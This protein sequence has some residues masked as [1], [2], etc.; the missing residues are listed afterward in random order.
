MRVTGIPLPITPR[1]GE[2]ALYDCLVDAVAFFAQAKGSCS[3]VVITNSL[4]LWITLFQRIKPGSVAFVSAK[5][6]KSSLEFAFLPEK[7][8]VQIL[9][10]PTLEEISS[11][12][13]AESPASPSSFHE[14]ESIA[15]EDQVEAD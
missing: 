13:Q 2:S 1:L 3:F 8:P 7:I 9:A 10:W 15:E 11:S 12:S 5:G 14:P 4:P 6:P